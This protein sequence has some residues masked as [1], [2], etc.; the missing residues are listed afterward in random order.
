MNEI[1]M[2][3][4]YDEWNLDTKAAGPAFAPLADWMRSV[5]FQNNQNKQMKSN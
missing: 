2:I 1:E 4:V 3:F 5:P